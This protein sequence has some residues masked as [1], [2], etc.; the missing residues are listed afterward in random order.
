MSVTLN[1]EITDGQK[2]LLLRG[3]RYVQRSALLEMKEPALDVDPERENQLEEIRELVDQ[4]NGSQTAET[5][6][7]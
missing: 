5:A 4:L 3:L 6:A 7:K 2:D 1:V